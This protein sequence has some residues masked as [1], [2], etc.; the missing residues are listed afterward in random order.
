MTISYHEERQIFY[1]EL[2]LAITQWAH[3]EHALQHLFTSS[4][5]AY[6]P[7]VGMTFNEIENFRSKQTV[8]DCAIKMNIKSKHHDEW[9][10]LLDRL[11]QKGSTRNRIAHNYVKLYPDNKPG[12]RLLL[13]HGN[14]LG[15]R[16]IALY[17]YEFYAL[18]TD[19]L[20]FAN[21]VT[22]KKVPPLSLDEPP[23]SPLSLK[24]LL[25]QMRASTEPPHRPL[26]G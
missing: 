18:S 16:D 21:K 13:P 3:V 20:N 9:A 19:L 7:V 2:G 22:G 1:Y 4:F 12:R 23:K 8:A 25:N 11:K 26:R 6:D 10:D 5:A 24:F 15:I 17:R 14:G